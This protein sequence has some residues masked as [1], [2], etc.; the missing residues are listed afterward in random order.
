M[1][2]D[3]IKILF[4]RSIDNPQVPQMVHVGR[5][6]GEYQKDLLTKCMSRAIAFVPVASDFEVCGRELS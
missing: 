5:N 2:L 3:R 6:C 4:P 1:F